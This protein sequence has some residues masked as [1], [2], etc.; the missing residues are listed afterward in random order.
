MI[1]LFSFDGPMYRD[2]NGVYCNTTITSEMFSRYF[3]VVDKLI[4]V[5]RTLHLDQDL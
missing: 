5:I 2:C 1:G 3:H 4:V